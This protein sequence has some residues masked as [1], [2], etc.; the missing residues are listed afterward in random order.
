ML[1]VLAVIRGVVMVVVSIACGAHSAKVAELFPDEAKLIATS[2][3]AQALYYLKP[4][5]LMH[6]F[7][8]AG[9]RPRNQSDDHADAT[10]ALREMI[11]SGYLSKAVAM[12]TPKGVVTQI[13]RQPGPISYI[14][15][16][17]SAQ[18]FDE[19]ANRALMLGTDETSEQTARVIAAQGSRAAL[20]GTDT[21]AIISKHHALQRMLRRVEVRI[22]FAPALAAAMPTSRP[23]ARR[24]MPQVL[25]VIT[26]VALLHQRQRSSKPLQHGDTI[27]ATFDD[28]AVARRLLL[29]PMSRSLGGALPDAVAR[30]G[31]RLRAE[32]G[33]QDFTSTDAAKASLGVSSKG[34]V[35]DYLRALDAAGWFECTEAGR[36]SK[37]SLWKAVADPPPVG[38]TWLPTI[39]QLAGSKP[40]EEVPI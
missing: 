39:D 34:K 31:E 7:V 6:R 30:F 2:I 24:A 11:G 37:P 4:G 29:G 40:D 27:E 20:P 28:Y 36:G 5:T 3:T 19:D 15:S 13:I 23:E 22:A 14:E 10:K 16:T 9:E 26:A 18:V 21:S 33:D 38:A 35:N 17:T 12:S 8:V 32:F 1:M 25:S